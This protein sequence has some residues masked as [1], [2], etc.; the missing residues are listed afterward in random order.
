M[1]TGKSLHAGQKGTVVKD[2][3]HMLLIKADDEKYTNSYKHPEME[4]KYFQLD[5]RNYKVLKD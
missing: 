3:G 1:A 4:G 2:Y 5:S